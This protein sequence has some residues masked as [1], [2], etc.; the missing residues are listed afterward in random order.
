M[1]IPDEMLNILYGNY[2]GYICTSDRIDQP[3]VVPV[4][5]IYDEQSQKIFF[6]SND[7]SKKIKNILENP[8]VSIT[9][10]IRDPLNPFNNEGVMVQG[11]A[12][13]TE[14]EPI[15]F[16]PEETLQL[17]R[18]IYMEFKSKYQ[19]VI[20]NKPLGENDIIVQINIRKMVYWRGPHFKSVRISRDGEIT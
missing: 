14:K 13:I 5:F 4:F 6:I 20:E 16:L 18:D 19:S 17:Y 3:H 12:I 9:V 10:D 7:K 11:T 15:Y 2:F 8:N 1:R